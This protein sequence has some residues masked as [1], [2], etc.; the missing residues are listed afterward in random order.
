MIPDSWVEGFRAA[1]EEW[2][3]TSTGRTERELQ[4]SSIS[5]IPFCQ[6]TGPATYSLALGPGL[7]TH[8]YNTASGPTHK[9][10]IRAIAEGS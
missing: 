8:A 6:H 2:G 4:L 7:T 10:P 3:R 5:S 9:R 1:K